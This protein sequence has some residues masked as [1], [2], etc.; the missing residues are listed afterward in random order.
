MQSQ[1]QTIFDK[2]V[3]RKSHSPWSAPAFLVPKKSAHGKPKCRFCVDF[4]ALNSVTK[5]NSYP[6][7]NFEETV[8]TLYGSKYFTVL[9]F[10]SGFWQLHIA[11][12]HKEGTAFSAPSGHYEFQRLPFGLANSLANFQRLM[13]TVL[14]DLIGPQCWAFIDIIF[15]AQ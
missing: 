15:P 12:S 5:L 10:Y 7:P 8:S 14:R 2:G 1:V 11:E 3:I 9:D 13:D 6:V 4:S